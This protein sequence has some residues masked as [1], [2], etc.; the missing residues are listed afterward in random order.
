MVGA[1]FQMV[2]VSLRWKRRMNGGSGM[3]RTSLPLYLL[4]LRSLTGH[5]RQTWGVCVYDFCNYVE[6]Y[7]RIGNL[8]SYVVSLTIF[9]TELGT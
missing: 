8:V 6:N 1:G 5:F 9:S 2:A 3:G 7:M 4:S